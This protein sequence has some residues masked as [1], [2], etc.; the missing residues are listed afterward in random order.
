MNATR[1]YI[2][3]LMTGISEQ[4]G[5][6]FKPGPKWM[7]NIKTKTLEYNIIDL[8]FT[9]IMI[10][11][12]CIIH[13]SGHLSY[14]TPLKKTPLLEQYPL[15]AMVYGVM[16]DMRIERKQEI[17]WGDWSCV[18][19]AITNEG[20]FRVRYDQRIPPDKKKPH[21]FL[22]DVM[23]GLLL[24]Y[25]W[26]QHSDQRN[27]ISYDLSYAPKLLNTY[28]AWEKEKV[29]TMYGNGTIQKIVDSNTTQDVQDVTDTYVFP[30]IEEYLK[31][32]PKEQQIQMM[33]SMSYDKSPTSIGRGPE[34]EYPQRNTII[35]TDTELDSI[36]GPYARVLAGNLARILQELRSTRFTGAHKKGRLLSKN[37]YKVLTEEKRIFSRKT[38]PNV[39]D[40][41]VIMLLD[42]S[43]S[44]SGDRHTN[45]YIAAHLLKLT[46]EQLHFPITYIKFNDS[47]RVLKT[48]SVYRDF[49]GGG[50][51]DS[52]AL[53]KAYEF[54]DPTRQNLVLVLSDGSICTYIGHALKKLRDKG[55]TVI[56]VGVAVHDNE[57]KE[58]YGTAINVPD[59]KQLPKAL[60]NILKTLIH[61]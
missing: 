24:H 35:P 29:K 56:G 23:C 30:H 40:Y 41:N 34:D 6:T 17:K 37:T 59:T 11:K 45:T 44:M 2:E 58:A 46:C 55:A 8:I 36:Y 27:I 26:G 12:G 28:R 33:A 14:T 13:E 22:T 10:V 61:R 31:Q 4:E 42:E 5:I 16:E 32:I 15:M 19:L 39:P 1:A 52:G 49:R 50:N 38:T 47:V 3:G 20:G 21:D 43:G 57:I 9:D 48:L 51:N 60:L 7:V 54:L 53:N 18:A 25:T